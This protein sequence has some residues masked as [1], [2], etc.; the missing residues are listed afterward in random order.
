MTVPPQFQEAF[1]NIDSQTVTLTVTVHQWREI[2]TALEERVSVA[3]IRMHEHTVI[4]CNKIIKD[5]TA[6]VEPQ[7]SAKVKE[8]F[9]QNGLS[10]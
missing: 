7:V 10:Q 8:V 2:R 6:Q 4:D 3:V 5:L 1:K 9:E